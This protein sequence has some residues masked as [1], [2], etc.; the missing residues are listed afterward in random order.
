MSGTATEVGP[1]AAEAGEPLV[2]DIA[3]GFEE[4]D[5]KLERPV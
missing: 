1:A 5:G 4:E 3:V 2:A